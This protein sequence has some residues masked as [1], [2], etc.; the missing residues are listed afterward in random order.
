M[1]KLAFL[2]FIGLVMMPII[3]HAGTVIIPHIYHH[4][5][6]G[7][8]VSGKNMLGLYLAANV[9]M[10][11]FYF[12]RTVMW[13][14]TRP[15]R[16]TFVEYVIWSDG[17][18]IFVDLVAIMFGVINGIGLLFMTGAWISNHI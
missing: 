18:Y 1:K 10:L 16:D 5:H 12:C 15:T 17:E 9:F 3:T 6:H 11:A 8:S 2:L 14:I 13:Y 4:S 7:G